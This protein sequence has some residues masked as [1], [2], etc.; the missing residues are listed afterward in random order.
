V[1]NMDKIVKIISVTLN[2]GIICP[3][4]DVVDTGAAVEDAALATE[5]PA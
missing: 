1:N 5:Y 2:C 3:G 4:C